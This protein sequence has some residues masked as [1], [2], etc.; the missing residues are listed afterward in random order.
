MTVPNEE[1]FKS[2][3][4]KAS[5]FSSRESS[6]T[7]ST[8]PSSSHTSSDEAEA[9]QDLKSQS[10]APFVLEDRLL[11]EPRK[12]RVAI[13]GAGLAGITAGI[14]LPIKVPGIELTIFVKNSDVS[15]VFCD[16]AF[17]H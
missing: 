17:L 2:Q 8:Y 13:I 1:H 11:D 3:E 14:L 12:L 4:N 10:N 9:G 5:S 6:L 15:G 7:T 16:F